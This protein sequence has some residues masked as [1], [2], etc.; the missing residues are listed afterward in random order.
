MPL[1]ALIATAA[2]G[3][4]S[5]IVT[6]W[7]SFTLGQRLLWLTFWFAGWFACAASIVVFVAAIPLLGAGHPIVSWLLGLIPSSVVP[8]VSSI[9]GFK[10]C[11]EV[12]ALKDRAFA[13]M[14]GLKNG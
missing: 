4:V 7:Y 9:V 3:A 1:P 14:G 13:I 12:L 10:V 6:A 2:G 11:K 5:T 8:I